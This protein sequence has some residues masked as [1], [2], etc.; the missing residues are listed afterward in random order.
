MT[1]SY[2]KNMHFSP[3]LDSQLS[4]CGKYKKNRE[5]IR[6]IYPKNHEKF[7]NGV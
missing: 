1:T 6:T 4:Y 2:S 5:K 3:I 7:K